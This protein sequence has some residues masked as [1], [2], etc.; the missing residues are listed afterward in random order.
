M[1]ILQSSFMHQASAKWVKFQ[2]NLGFPEVPGIKGNSDKE[3]KR[4]QMLEEY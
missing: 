1:E 2:K 3:Q 4:K